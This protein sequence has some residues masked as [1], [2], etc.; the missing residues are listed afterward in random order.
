[1]SNGWFATRDAM[2][3]QVSLATGGPPTVEPLFRGHIGGADVDE[4]E[5]LEV[6]E[7]EHVA[8]ADPGRE[9]DL[10]GA[11]AV[12]EE[13]GREATIDGKGAGSE[14]QPLR[15]RRAAGLNA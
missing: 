15:A 9:L 7:V 4:L 6:F 13:T 10:E 14:G 12:V 1:M 5:L 3:L 2:N 11:P 8:A